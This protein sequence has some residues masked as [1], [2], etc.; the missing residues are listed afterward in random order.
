[1]LEMELLLR[2]PGLRKWR[3][4]TIKRNELS[5]HYFWQTWQYPARSNLVRWS[6]ALHGFNKL[7][8]TS[9]DINSRS[10]HG[11]RL[12]EAHVR[13]N[14]R[15]AFLGMTESIRRNTEWYTAHSK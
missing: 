5:C 3:S 2:A 10:Y 9:T 13:E 14:N 4:I 15:K 7:I 12:L 11:V 1:M 6:G 8:A